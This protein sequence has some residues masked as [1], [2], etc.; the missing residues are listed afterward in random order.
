MSKES[1]PSWGFER[2][3]LM[4]QRNYEAWGLELIDSEKLRLL[5]SKDK[6]VYL[7]SFG[8]LAPSTHNTQPWAFKLSQNMD[9]FEVYLDRDRVLPAS[10]HLGRQA[11]L[12]VGASIENIKTVASCYGL[13]IGERE[14]EVS[15]DEVMSYSRSKNMERYV[16]LSEL[17]VV[18]TV[19]PINMSIVRAILSRR[20][21]RGKDYD[22]SRDIPEE[23]MNRLRGAG[24]NGVEVHLLR[25]GDGGVE[26]IA[27]IQSLIDA[28]VGNLSDFKLEL[29][30]W[31]KS[32]DTRDLF[33]MPTSTF[34]LDEDFG[35]ELIKD[36]RGEIP[37][38]ATRM[39]GISKNSLNGIRNA[40]MVGVITVDEQSVGSW[41]RAGKV[42]S[43]VGNL[44][45]QDG[46]ENAF[47]AGIA[48][49]AT[50]KFG[51][52]SPII[53]GFLKNKFSTNNDPI[54]LFRS[55]YGGENRPPHAPRAPLEEVLI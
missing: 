27:S 7:L 20:V 31:M 48:E 42:V 9:G 37:H 1:E 24:E 47:F 14:S 43:R 33:G 49:A 22:L 54:I 18:G 21:N 16:K 23:V 50:M 51:V 45:E 11:V 8:V 26:T 2:N 46:V 10:D 5:S 17:E 28:F 35:M 12:S 55:G 19:N 25:R 52:V 38:M 39:G 53:S 30:E 6:L 29:G 36:L 15:L 13:K 41:L 40:G 3:S 44:L 34:L 4:T 32:F